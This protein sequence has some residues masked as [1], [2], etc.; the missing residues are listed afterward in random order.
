[1]I[2]YRGPKLKI[3]KKLGVLPG[4]TQKTITETNSTNKTFSLK[5][6]SLL[7]NYKIQLNEKQKL[8]YNYNL[9]EKQLRNYYN[10]SKKQFGAKENILLTILEARLDNI[11]F[12]L[13]F[14]S[15]ITEAR[16]YINHNHIIVNNKTVNF[17]SYNCKLNDKINI[18]NDS[19]IMPLI[20]K[21]FQKQIDKEALIEN[22]LKKLNLNSSNFKFILPSY[23]KLDRNK[24]EGT[25]CSSIKIN[26]SLLK[27]NELKILEFYSH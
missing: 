8:K 15:T 23:L 13:G 7:D 25:I 26:M 24:I 12:R 19:K 14:S 16:Q 6:I 20:L 18:K 9:S 22:R 10:K 21:N 11:L 27:V 5:Q 1:M 4:F 2:K 3:I 17:A